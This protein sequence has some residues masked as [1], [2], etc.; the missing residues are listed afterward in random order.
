MTKDIVETLER[1]IG[2]NVQDKCAIKQLE[3]DFL[4]RFW[5]FIPGYIDKVAI[6]A[7]SVD[8]RLLFKKNQKIISLD[9]IYFPRADQYLEVTRVTDP[10][11]GNYQVR[12]RPGARPLDDQIKSLKYNKISLADVGAFDGTTM[13]RVCEAV[14][15][16]GIEIE[17]IY[18]CFSS[19]SANKS[20]N[21]S[22]TLKVLMLFEFYEWIELRDLLGIDGRNTFMMGGD[23]FF[24][25]YWENLEAWA[26]IPKK[27]E[28]NVERL[29][30]EYNQKIL[31]ILKEENVD[32]SRIGKTMIYKGGR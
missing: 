20:I 17:D 2:L 26:S 4:E 23:R 9:R 22:R 3:N 8:T 29:C 7:S 18:L 5:E 27:Y 30:K 12:E 15:K 19:N 1:K 28:K 13:L 14:E 6:D 25:P 31:D 21:S 10:S 32:I 24:I 16:N 11:T